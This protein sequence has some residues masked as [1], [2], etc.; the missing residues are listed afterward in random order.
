MIKRNVAKPRQEGVGNSIGGPVWSAVGHR[1]QRRRAELGFSTVRVARW[2]AIPTESYE[3][4]ERG[5]PIPAS[6]LAQIADLFEIPLVWFFEGV[7]HDE[8]E[9][10]AET[11]AD[12]G[13]P[14]DA[15]PAV[16]RVATVE[17]RIEALA[18]SFRK[19]DFEGQQHLLALSRALSRSN[20]RSNAE[21]RRE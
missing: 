8:P 15:E 20:G 2:A 7:G 5:A 18:E 4:Y 16:Y 12:A 1:L 17:H 10:A 9:A 13:P 14:A 3:A 6:L 19:L 11:V 21:A